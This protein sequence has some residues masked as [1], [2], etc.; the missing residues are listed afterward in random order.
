MRT[1]WKIA[2]MLA[3]LA[4]V[5]GGG[6]LVLR[7]RGQATNPQPQRPG[8]SLA[9]EETNDPIKTEAGIE[10]RRDLRFENPADRPVTARL[11]WKDCD[12]SQVLAC[13]APAAWGDPDAAE[14]RKRAADPALAWQKLEQGGGGLTVPVGGVG[15]LRLTVKTEKVGDHIFGVELGVDDGEGRGRQ[16]LQV[17][18]HTDPSVRV[19]T[20]DDPGRPETDVGRLS[21]GDER[22]ARFLCYSTTRDRFQLTPAPPAGDPCIR[23][24]TPR[25]LTAEELRALSAKA[26]T[27]VR[28][29][30]RVAVT[31]RERADQARLDIGPFRRKVVWKTDVYPGHEVSAHVSGTVRGEVALAAPE[32]KAFIDLGTVSAPHP[33][34]VTFTLESRDPQLQLAVDEKGTLDFLQVDLLD[35]KDGTATAGGKSWQVRVVFRAGAP[36]MGQFPHPDRAEYDSP[37]ACCIAFLLSRPGSDGAPARRL[38]VPVRGTVRSY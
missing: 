1:I 11:T 38:L 3:L 22:T 12:C 6:F 8:P 36:F 10:G 15:L 16:R 30:Y 35:G 29:G 4:V 25:P 24:G 5:G 13:V 19:G 20:E 33:K 21:A 2:L 7:D 18:V 32:D 27:A 37:A 26:G 34:P 23:Y 31:V 28:A 9:I 14:L 17:Y